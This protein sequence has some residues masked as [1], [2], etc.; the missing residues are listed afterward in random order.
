MTDQQL[1][2]GPHED[3]HG[4]QAA[5]QER[6]DQ[7][8]YGPPGSDS[9][10]IRG[11]MQRLGDLVDRQQ[12][13]RR[14]RE[15]GGDLVVETPAGRVCWLS[16]LN[17]SE[18]NDDLVLRSD[19]RGPPGREAEGPREGLAPGE[20]VLDEDDQVVVQLAGGEIKLLSEL[21]DAELA[22]GYRVRKDLTVLDRN[23]ADDD[24]GPGEPLPF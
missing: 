24:F 23:D 20:E 8:Q 15:G 17:E 16:E 5:E 11:S 21:S 14:L 7:E 22:A 6:R 10:R 12:A 1:P 9:R 2:F 3:L 18:V 4:E 13:V 19:L